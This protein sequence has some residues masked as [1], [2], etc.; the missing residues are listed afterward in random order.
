MDLNSGISNRDWRIDE[1]VQ[2]RKLKPATTTPF[3][4][5]HFGIIWRYTRI[6]VTVEKATLNTFKVVTY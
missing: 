6:A 1:E 2:D 5:S 4:E 3:L